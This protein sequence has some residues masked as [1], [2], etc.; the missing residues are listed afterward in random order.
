[1]TRLARADAGGDAAAGV[2]PRA[3]ALRTMLACA[4]IMFASV[5]IGFYGIAVIVDQLVESVGVAVGL[6]SAGTSAFLLASCL[7]NPL[8]SSGMRRVGTRSTIA[9]GGLVA[10]AGLG[11]FALGHEPALLLSAFVLVGAGSAACSFLPVS[12]ILVGL[13]DATRSLGMTV[14]YSGGTLGG[15]LLAPV[16]L[17]ASGSIGFGPSLLLAAGVLLAVVGAGALWGLPAGTGREPAMAVPPVTTTGP[18]PLP[19]SREP[20]ASGMSLREAVRRGSFWWLLVALALTGSTVTAVQLQIL[21]IARFA[22]VANPG[23]VTVL[24]AIAV[25]VARF[26]GVVVLRVV[27]TRVLSMVVCVIQAASFLLVAFA[28]SEAAFFVGSALVGVSIGLSVLLSPLLTVD[29]IGRAHFA[30]VYAV[31]LAVTGLANG[32]GPVVMGTMF[33]PVAGY[34][35][36]L[37]VFAGLSLLAGAAFGLIRRTR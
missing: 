24:L 26:A 25:A 7:A 29:V 36:S 2:Q 14:G 19:D 34:A 3:S 32:I 9:I 8:V 11:M 15:I 13:P 28:P 27:S 12:T 18:L 5:G 4:L 31:I 21:T 6:V 37:A 17:A 23:L 22:D 35:F 33:D 20:A 10:A 16:L 1:M 30:R